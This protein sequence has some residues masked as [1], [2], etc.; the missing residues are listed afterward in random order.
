M[1]PL[2]SDVIP[3]RLIAWANALAQIMLKV[4]CMVHMHLQAQA[5]QE[6]NNKGH[7]QK[8]PIRLHPRWPKPTWASH[9][10]HMDQRRS[11]DLKRCVEEQ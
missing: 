7:A 2:P 10:L 3:T 5:R 9:T 6:A 11:E 8:D 4:Q 1:C